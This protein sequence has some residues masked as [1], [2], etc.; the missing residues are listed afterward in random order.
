[1]VGG[2]VFIA[3]TQLVFDHVGPFHD[4]VSVFLKSVA[5][6]Q[7]LSHPVFVPI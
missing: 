5:V 4:D 3:P 1:M 6:V 2:R 7:L